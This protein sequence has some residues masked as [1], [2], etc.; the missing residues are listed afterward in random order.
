MVATWSL[1]CGAK[2]GSGPIRPP[3]H[4]EIDEMVACCGPELELCPHWAGYLGVI[5]TAT[6]EP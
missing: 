4:L 5:D 6:D 1:A 3:N 2:L